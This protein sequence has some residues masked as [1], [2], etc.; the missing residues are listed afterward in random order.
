MKPE[1][2]V[3]IPLKAEHTALIAEY[4]QIHYVPDMTDQTPEKLAQYAQVPAMLT[5]GAIGCSAEQMAAL[6]RLGL[7]CALGAGYENIDLEAA[8]QRGVAV[9][10]G[11]S[12][13]DNCVADH[14]MALLLACVRRVVSG[15]AHIRQGGWRETLPPPPNVSGKRMGI[16]GLGTIGRQI[17]KRSLGFDMEIGYHNRRRVENE[18]FRYFGSA[19]ELAAW[20]DYL[21]VVTPGGA[22]TRHLVNAKVLEALGPEGFVVNVARGSVVDTEALAHALRHGIIAGAGLDVYES[23]PEPPAPLLDLQN[24]VLTPHVAGHS[25]EAIGAAYQ[26]F[27]DNATRYFAG[28]PMVSPIVE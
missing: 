26:R 8:K 5:N 3:L 16:L 6:P 25:P 1:L 28:Q 13:N 17:A 2:L 19:E 15:D 7:V 9:A 18:A 27:I 21:M 4:F 14:A 12:T 24:I 22:A 20:A 11:A 10:N 23:E